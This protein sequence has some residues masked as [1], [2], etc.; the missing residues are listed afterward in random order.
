MFQFELQTHI[1]ETHK[2]MLVYIGGVIK[3]IKAPPRVKVE[4]PD[5]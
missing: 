5:L 4:L 3:H 2:D 1:G